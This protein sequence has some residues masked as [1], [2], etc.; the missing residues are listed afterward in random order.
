[1]NSESIVVEIAMGL[2]RGTFLKPFALLAFF[3]DDGLFM[4][5]RT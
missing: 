5:S 2:G 4:S 3:C 1:M